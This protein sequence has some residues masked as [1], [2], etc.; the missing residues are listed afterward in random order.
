MKRMGVNEHEKTTS[1]AIVFAKFSNKYYSK[2]I[3]RSIE[4]V[5]PFLLF[6]WV[7]VRVCCVD[8]VLLDS[9]IVVVVALFSVQCRHTG[10][11]HRWWLIVLTISL[12]FCVCYKWERWNTGQ[13]LMLRNIVKH[14]MC[15]TEN[16]HNAIS[17]A[18]KWTLKLLFFW[19]ALNQIKWSPV[20]AFVHPHFNLEFLRF[21]RE[22]LIIC[23]TV[24]ISRKIM[25]FSELDQNLS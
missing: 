20:Y 25:E 6:S 2:N 21:D 22:M 1:H 12:S 18:S 16:K 7:C 14:E 5:Y 9:V 13:V 24:A 11:Q 3:T 8:V 15:A 4:N 10:G 23:S 17:F 19:R